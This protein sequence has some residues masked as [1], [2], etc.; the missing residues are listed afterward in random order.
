MMLA[1]TDVWQELLDNDELLQSQYDVIAGKWPE[2]YNEV[3]LIVDENN[4][5]YDYTLYALGILDQ[6]ELE[7][8]YQKIL[9]GEEVEC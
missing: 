2:N 4:E 7:E 1:E 5:I 9:D 3:V 8:K 6:D